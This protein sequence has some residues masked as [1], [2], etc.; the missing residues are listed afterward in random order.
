MTALWLSCTCLEGAVYWGVVQ[1]LYC[2][3]FFSLLSYSF[4]SVLDGVDEGVRGLFYSLLVFSK[5]DG[6]TGRFRKLLSGEG[7]EFGMNS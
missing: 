6:K 5:G 1:Y 7:K 3:L 2:F 4:L